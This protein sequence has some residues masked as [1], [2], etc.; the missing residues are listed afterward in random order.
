MIMNKT[1]IK[2]LTALHKVVQKNVYR[3]NETMHPESIV[4]I[5][6]KKWKCRLALILY[7]CDIPE[8]RDMSGVKHGEKMCYCVQCLTSLC[9]IP[10]LKVAQI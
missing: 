1:R 8:K 7:C 5:C 10:E 2:T 3:L 6:E 4:D 9:D